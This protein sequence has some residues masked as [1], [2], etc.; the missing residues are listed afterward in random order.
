[1]HATRTSFRDQLDH[2]KRDVV[3]LGALVSETISRGTDA[4]LTADDAATEAMDEDDKRVDRLTA[5]IEQDGCRLL[6]LQQPVASDLRALMTALRLAYEMERVGDLMVN[7]AAAA[8]GLRGHDLDPRAR[9]LVEQLGELTHALLCA[10]IDAYADGDTEA[11]TR[12]ASVHDEITDV[13]R[14]LV[15][16]LLQSAHAGVIDVD[17]AVQLALVGRSFER[18]GDHAFN[19][20]RRVR[21][22][23]NGS[24][25]ESK[26][27]VPR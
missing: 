22:M 9:G 11:S 20:V 1:M 18:V 14:R 26:R 10:A 6:A 2:V 17:A 3:R 27:L 25:I 15:E 23:V 4:F 21:Y 8:H 7:I 19:V 13:H 24:A 12:L 5:A 16:H